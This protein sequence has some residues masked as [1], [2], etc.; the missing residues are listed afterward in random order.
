M[1]RILPKSYEW[2]RISIKTK[3]EIIKNFEIEQ[4]NDVNDFAKFLTYNIGMKIYDNWY[5]G[6][7]L[8]FINT[9]G[10][11]CDLGISKFDE[12]F[13][14]TLAKELI[15]IISIQLDRCDAIKG[16]KFVNCILKT[17]VQEIEDERMRRFSTVRWMTGE[18]EAK[19]CN[20]Q[21]NSMMDDADAW[22]NID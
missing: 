18:E 19:E 13:Y 17:Y 21:F 2:K 8:D 15:E 11:K 22:G 7:W 14:P 4:S 5:E 10:V 1:K 3:I 16:R 6:K 9:Y 20:S 12:E